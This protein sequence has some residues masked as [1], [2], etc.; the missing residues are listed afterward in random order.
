MK[1][2][3]LSGSMHNDKEKLA[4][5]KM[6][7]SGEMVLVDTA[8]VVFSDFTPLDAEEI[9]KANERIIIFL[10]KAGGSVGKSDKFVLPQDRDCH[11][12]EPWTVIPMTGTMAHSLGDIWEDHYIVT[13]ETKS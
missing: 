1:L 10:E 2:K 11:K 9:R 12:G 3:D 13:E 8:L 4:H 6:L 7:A 5:M